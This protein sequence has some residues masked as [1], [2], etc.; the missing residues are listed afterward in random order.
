M[1]V[2]TSLDM[3]FGNSQTGNFWLSYYLRHTRATGEVRGA[4]LLFP[5]SHFGDYDSGKTSY[6][7]GEY[8]FYHDLLVGL[9]AMHFHFWIYITTTHLVQIN[10][11]LANIWEVP[12]FW[13]N[14]LALHITID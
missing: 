11:L 5:R 8:D 14:T 10:A 7:R 9:C 1:L 12:E 2:G 4:P 13:T 6:C 3:I